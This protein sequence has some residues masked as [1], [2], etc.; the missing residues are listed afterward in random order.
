[1]HCF[2]FWHYYIDVSKIIFQQRMT[3][4]ARLLHAEGLTLV[5]PSSELPQVDNNARK[6]DF[7]EIQQQEEASE[8]E[9][10]PGKSVATTNEEE[11]PNTSPEN[12]NNNTM[13]RKPA[14]S[15]AAKKF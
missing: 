4:I 3:E 15:S 1:M 14:S 5:R 7:S 6:R 2:F 9:S 13:S 10:T 11:E 12:K 8:A